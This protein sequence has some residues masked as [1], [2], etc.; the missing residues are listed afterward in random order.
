MKCWRVFCRDAGILAHLFD[1]D[2]SVLTLM[3]EGNYL[4]T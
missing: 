2:G 4:V 3:E 1:L